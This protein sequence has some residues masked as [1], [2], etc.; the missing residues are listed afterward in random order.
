MVFVFVVEC[1]RVIVISVV[2]QRKCL[3]HRKSSS[4]VSS[5]MRCLTFVLSAAFDAFVV[6][7]SRAVLVRTVVL[8]SFGEKN[9]RIESAMT[10]RAPYRLRLAVEIPNSVFFP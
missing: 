3:V 2:V 6:L 8:S 7:V 1:D 4:F 5:L 10:T 9:A